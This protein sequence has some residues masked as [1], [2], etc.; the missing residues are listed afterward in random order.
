MQSALIYEQ[1]AEG[2]VPTPPMQTGPGLMAAC[3]S[4]LAKARKARTRFY[5]TQ[6]WDDF[7]SFCL[8]KNGVLELL[9][10]HEALRCHLSAEEKSIMAQMD[11][12][13]NNSYTK[14]V[15]ATGRH[16]MMRVLRGW[17]SRKKTPLTRAQKLM[18]QEEMDDIAAQRADKT[19]GRDPSMLLAKQSFRRSGRSRSS[20]A[21]S[22]RISDWRLRTCSPRSSRRGRYST[23]PSAGA[24]S[25]FSPRASSTRSYRS[26][27]AFSWPRAPR[28]SALQC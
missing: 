4:L 10:L 20:S 5:S 7:V 3:T 21:K 14:M 26:R 11:A 1:W 22:S 17:I 8:S 12:K 28:R 23:F 6:S 16:P 19:K 27:S 24:W 13:V 15:R 2:E 9:T 18:V 25:S